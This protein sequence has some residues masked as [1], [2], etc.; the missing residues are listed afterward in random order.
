MW[1]RIKDELVNMST[2]KSVGISKG[3]Q[4]KFVLYFPQADRKDATIHVPFDTEEEAKAAFAKIE[5]VLNVALRFPD[6]VD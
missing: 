6:S 5:A 1:I 3:N 4:D 2:V